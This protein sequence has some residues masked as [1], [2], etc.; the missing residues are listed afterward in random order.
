VGSAA[1]GTSL[2]GLTSSLLLLKFNPCLW[3]PSLIH[4]SHMDPNFQSL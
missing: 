3:F 2:Q 4:M 1:N